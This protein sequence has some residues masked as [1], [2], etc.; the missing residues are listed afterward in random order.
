MEI[1]WLHVYRIGAYI[2][3]DISM[4]IR[5]KYVDKDMDLDGKVY[6]HGQPI[7]YIDAS[8]IQVV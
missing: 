5:V 1:Q 6:I 8:H 7:V 2:D 3:M 4:D